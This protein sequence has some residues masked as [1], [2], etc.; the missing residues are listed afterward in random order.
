[1]EKT[2]T[3]AVNTARY[4]VMSTILES[5]DPVATALAKNTQEQLQSIKTLFDSLLK[6]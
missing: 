1:M 4:R 3:D 6:G 2:I 5:G